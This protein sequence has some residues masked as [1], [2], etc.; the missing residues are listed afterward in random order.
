MSIAEWDARKPDEGEQP[1]F[2]TD[3]DNLGARDQDV[4]QA[5]FVQDEYHCPAFEATDVVVDLGM[6]IGGFACRAWMNGSRRVYGFEVDADSCALA[7]R[8]S[9]KFGDGISCFNLA[10]IG[11]NHVGPVRYNGGW[12]ILTSEGGE[13]EAR[14]LDEIIEM[15]GPIRFLKIDIEG[16][17]WPVL[18]TCTRLSEVQEI[19]GEYHTSLVPH[20]DLEGLPYPKHRL[21]LE[22]FLDD[23]GYQTEV[24]MEVA[25]VGNF[26]AWRAR[27]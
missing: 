8:N 3:T 17:E 7:I 23:Q 4:W 6:H 12:S 20:P 18:Y 1:F 16:S 15:T 24:G 25:Y 22:Q 9:E 14:S 19:A 26:H 21:G 5:A 11:E 13:I 10:V 2:R 27:G